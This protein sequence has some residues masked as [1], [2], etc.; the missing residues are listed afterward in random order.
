MRAVVEKKSTLFS[1]WMSA[2]THTC[3]NG[4]STRSPSFR[5]T[6]KLQR[7]SLQDASTHNSR[8]KVCTHCSPSE[9][10]YR[11]GLQLGMAL[12]VATFAHHPCRRTRCAAV[13]GVRCPTSGALWQ[14]GRRVEEWPAPVDMVGRH[15]AAAGA[16]LT[17]L[18]L[19]HPEAHGPAQLYSSSTDCMAQCR[20]LICAFGTDS[21]V[22][23]A[24]RP[25]GRSA[26]CKVKLAT[27]VA[28]QQS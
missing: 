10:V 11:Y 26:A 7:I 1:W 23:I 13:L 14:T 25:H 27:L 5:I 8:S 12:C 19:P 2:S 6:L 16:A 22:R 18:Q 20:P 24:S 4:R 3:R 15:P 21:S 28:Q 9:P 17:A